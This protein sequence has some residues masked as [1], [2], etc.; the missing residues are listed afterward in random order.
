MYNFQ[1]KRYF[2]MPDYDFADGRVKVI[3][4]GKIINEDFARI[5]SRNPNMGL[6]EIIML[7]KVQKKKSLTDEEIIQLKKTKFIEGRK[8]N[9]YL[10]KIV[11]EPTKDPKLKADYIKNRGLDDQFLKKYIFDYIKMGKV[12]KKDIDKFIWGKLPDVLDD[13][14]KKNKIKN[15]L[16]ELRKEEKIL[17]SQYGYWE[18]VD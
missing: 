12:S 13:N 11:I 1:K 7:D 18:I 3:I 10:S 2:P 9:I 17:S 4:T 8:P 15:I 6:E 14:K 16:Q 5:L